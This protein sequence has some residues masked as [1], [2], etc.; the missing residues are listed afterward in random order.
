MQQWIDLARF[1]GLQAQKSETS[2][3]SQSQSQSQTTESANPA[4]LNQ[5]VECVNPAALGCNT[6]EEAGIDETQSQ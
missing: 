6:T 3:L 4:E 5:T 2:L 1:T